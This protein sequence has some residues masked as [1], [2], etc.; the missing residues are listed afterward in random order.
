MIYHIVAASENNVIGVDNGLPWRLP[1]DLRFF[2][3]K[4]WGMPIIMGRRTFESFKQPLKGRLNIVLTHQTNWQA[5]GAEVVH[6]LSAALEKA[7]ETDARDVFIIGGGQIFKESMDLVERVYLTRVH[8]RVDG[9][10][11]YPPL[12]PGEW[13][14]IDSS[15][16][17][18]DDKNKLAYTR[19]LWERNR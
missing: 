18:P 16:H 3:N 8:T 1:N 7:R 15:T 12:E 11:E 6:D 10:T 14:L 4:T 19:E 2:K 13:R 5:P 9:D 17:E